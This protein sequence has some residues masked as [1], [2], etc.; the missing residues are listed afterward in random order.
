MLNAWK[1][2]CA[3]PTRAKIVIPKGTYALSRISLNGPCK[4]PIELQVMGTILAPANPSAFKEPNWVV[5]NGVDRL[6]V[7]GGGVFDGQGAASWGK[8]TCAKEKYCAALPIV[9][10]FYLSVLET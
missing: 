4:S 5:F 8:N 9:R 1:E 2:A 10:L 7:S 6:T 3:S